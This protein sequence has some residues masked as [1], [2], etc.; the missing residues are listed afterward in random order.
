MHHR[1][2]LLRCHLTL[3]GLS[4]NHHAAGVKNTCVGASI[5]HRLGQSMVYSETFAVTQLWLAGR[6][7]T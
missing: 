5:M 6:M 7:R 4:Y 3:D 2:D 1:L